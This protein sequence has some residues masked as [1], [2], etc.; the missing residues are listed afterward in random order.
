MSTPGDFVGRDCPL[1][2]AENSIETDD[3][4]GE[5]ACT[6]CAKVIAMGLE[7]SLSTRFLKDVTFDDA[8]NHAS[9]DDVGAVW[10]MSGGRSAPLTR[11]EAVE[12]AQGLTGDKLASTM[13]TGGL[14]KQYR[15][16]VLHPSMNRRLETLCRLTRRP[17]ESVLREAVL[18]AKQFVG[19]RRA[20]GEKIDKMN[21]TSAACIL[22]AAERLAAPIPLAELR[23]IDPTVRDVERRREDIIRELQLQKEYENLREAFPLNL[24]RYYMRLLHLSRDAYENAVIALY[25]VIQSLVDSHP[26]IAHL[27]EAERIVAAVLLLRFDRRLHWPERPKYSNSEMSSSSALKEQYEGFASLAQLPASRLFKVMESVSRVVPA[28]QAPFAAEY[29]RLIKRAAASAS[30]SSSPPT[31]G[32]KRERSL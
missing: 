22:L 1:C 32:Q 12:A 28:M 29:D 27:V 21:E 4:H 16:T 25:S 2:G 31:I 7:E 11:S 17:E 19:V 15:R 9:R 10:S 8:D 6:S 18:L 23:L 13:S 14:E 24:S 20:R 5:V 3:V 26:E 30:A